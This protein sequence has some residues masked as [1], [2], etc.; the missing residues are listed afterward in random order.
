MPLHEEGQQ[1]SCILIATLGLGGLG[2]R[3]S[4]LGFGVGTE[5]KNDDEL[6]STIAHPLCMERSSGGGLGFSDF[7]TLHPKPAERL[8]H[9]AD[10]G[11]D[12]LE[13]NEL[14]ISPKWVLYFLLV[15]LS[16]V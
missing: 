14:R 7:L 13:G 12:R 10:Y 16:R 15:E 1:L 3:V 9:H 8:G 11:G 6:G 5:I 2:F 4:G